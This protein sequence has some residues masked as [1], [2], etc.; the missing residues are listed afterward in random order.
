MNYENKEIIWP[1]L[2]LKHGLK[3]GIRLNPNAFSRTAIFSTRTFNGGA[4]RP[5]ADNQPIQ[6]ESIKPYEVTQIAGERLS[7]SDADLFF[8]LLAKAYADGPPKNTATVSFKRSEAFAGIGMANSG[9]A[10][11]LFEKSLDRLDKAKF[12]WSWDNGASGLRAGLINKL[13]WCAPGTEAFDYWLSLDLGIANLLLEKAWSLLDAEERS[14]IGNDPLAKGLHT[15]YTS[16]E[17][18]PFPMKASTLKRIMD[19]ES[20]Q[21]SKWRIA[22]IKALARVKAATNWPTCELMDHGPTKDKVVIQKRR[23]ATRKPSLKELEEV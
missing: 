10:L 7:Q 14:K 21:D 17:D 15:F 23:K 8:W 18:N 3:N 22:L 2:E 4:I 16:H 6:I 5:S 19:R 11:K 13:G 9:A 1:K 20:M 12:R